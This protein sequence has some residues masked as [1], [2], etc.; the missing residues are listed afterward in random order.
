MAFPGCQEL[1]ANKYIWRRWPILELWGLRYPRECRHRLEPTQASVQVGSFRLDQGA[2]KLM[3]A[4]LDSPACWTHFAQYFGQLSPRRLASSRYSYG[5]SSS[6]TYPTLCFALKSPPPAQY[7]TVLC[8]Y[9]SSIYSDHWLLAWLVSEA[10]PGPYLGSPTEWWFLPASS[11][12]SSFWHRV[13]IAHASAFWHYPPFPL[14]SMKLT[15]GIYYFCRFY[16][17]ILNSTCRPILRCSRRWH[18][19]ACFSLACVYSDWYCSFLV[20]NQ[21][22]PSLMLVNLTVNKNDGN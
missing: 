3:D 4:H 9:Q 7:S 6:L 21:L 13:A 11:Y 20:R 10:L 2:P 5:L 15:S 18:L 12:I 22:C 14:S 19:F 8:R 1:K 17:P 16:S